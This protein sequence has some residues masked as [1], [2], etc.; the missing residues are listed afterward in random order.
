LTQTAVA[1]QTGLR[2]DRR[3]NFH[4]RETVDVDGPQEPKRCRFGDNSTPVQINIM[5]TLSRAVAVIAC[6]L[7]LIRTSPVRSDDASDKDKDRS[8]ES[9]LVAG[10]F[11]GLKLRSIGPALKSGR[12]SDIAVD[13]QQPNTWYVAV[14]SGGVW[15]TTNAGTTFEPIFDDY[16]SY[17]IGCVTID[18]SNRNTVWVGTG[19][20]VGGRHVGYGDG[21]YRSR[22]G[23][24]S[25]ENVGLTKSEHIARILVDP[26]D[27]NVVYV[28]AQGPL[29]APGGERGLYKTTNGG[30][31]W[32][33]VLAKGPYTGVTD[34]VMDPRNPD[35]LYA[36][37]HQRHRTVWALIN[38]GPETGIHKST[39]GGATWRQLKRGLP[40]D[41]MGKIGLAISPQK[42]DVLYAAIE[43]AGRT[44]GVWRSADGG[45]S[46]SKQSDHVSGGTG[47]HYYQEIFAD[48]HRF[49]VVYHVSV[50]LTRTEDGG[51]T[52]EDVDRSSKHVDNHAV[53]FHPTDRDFLVVGCDGGVYWSRDYAKTYTFAENLPLT[54]FYKLDVDYDEPFYHVVGGTQD[55]NT[56]HGPARTGNISGIRNSD[57]IVT[58]GGDGHDCAI[59]P[60][61]PNII[62][63]ESQQGYLRRYDRATGQSVRIRPQPA[64]GEEGLRFNWDSPIHISPHDPARIYHGSKKLHMSPDRG[65][66]WTDLSGDLS[67][68]IDR[69]TLKVMDRVWSIDSLYDLYAMSQYGNITS[70]SESPVQKDL[71]YVGTDDGLIQVTEDGGKTWRKTERFFDVPERAFVNDVKADLHDADTVYVCLDDHKTGD[72]Q[73]YVIKSTDRGRTWTSIVGD[74][75]DRHLVWRIIQDHENPRLLFLGTEFGLFFTIN[76]GEKWIKLKGG[77]PVIPFRDLEIQR[78]ENDLVG[79]TFGRSFYV[80]DDYTP[81]RTVSDE[82]LSEN[83]FVLFPPPKALLYVP[84]NPLGGRVGSQ[85]DA[86][87]TA[88]NP[89]FGATFTYYLKEGLKTQQQQRAEREKKEAAAGEDTDPP[90]WEDLTAEERE[91][92]PQFV[93]TITAADG[94]LVNRVNGSTSAGFHRTAWNLRYASLT[95]RGEG[96]LVSPGTYTVT[97]TRRVRDEQTPLGEPQTFE[98]VTAYEPTLPEVDKQQA[99]TFQTAAGD[100]QRA[101]IAADRTLDEMLQRVRSIKSVAK[102][103]NR[104]PD[105]VYDRARQ[106]ELALLDVQV[107]LVGDGIR[108]RQSQ[109]SVPSIIARTQTALGDTLSQTHGPT[110]TSRE[111]YEIAKTEFAEVR[112]QLNDTI[113]G[114]LKELEQELDRLGAPWTPGREIPEVK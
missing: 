39:D 26:R 52:W 114:Q 21:V 73:P 54:Q 95:G 12:I 58:I 35:V 16:G 82:L 68:G 48:P 70:I 86:F 40:G 93:F 22:D 30:E 3:E 102:E 20:D 97:A 72:F 41:D 28:A 14:G 19:E 34:V 61:N 27:S 66:S 7:L 49:D 33:R 98:V 42:P 88:D 74:L 44:G 11:S 56:L 24:K 6:S 91:E 29:W 106:I 75:P 1:W 36:A 107:H 37:T 79:A 80:L 90:K 18:P 47:P 81:L 101:V 51:K 38:G 83:E 13:Q 50:R 99:L 69:F 2:C 43:L 67:R 104:V 78:R 45:E 53:A 65:D 100:L 113:R 87:Y 105:D 8:G 23:G 31:S 109:E 5:P 25:F 92:R 111:Q 76:G 84:S 112:T 17:S 89:G 62:Y 59:D 46:W 103:S 96:P 77:V 32:T 71:I 64:A 110:Q 108:A 85:G 55:N 4:S 15:K 94:S 60:T 9:K 57:W 63:C 10:T